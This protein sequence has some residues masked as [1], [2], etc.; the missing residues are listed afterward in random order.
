MDERRRSLV[1]GRCAENKRIT[2]RRACLNALGAQRSILWV[3]GYQ[4]AG[5][6]RTTY[7][8]Y[9]HHRLLLR[10]SQRPLRSERRCYR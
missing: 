8:R 5:S 2:S 6:L 4:A 10:S 1:K 3:G 7:I 9:S